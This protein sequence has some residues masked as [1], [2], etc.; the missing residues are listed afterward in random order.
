MA[1]NNEKYNH[2]MGSLGN[3]KPFQ[4][5]II[6]STTAPIIKRSVTNVT[7]GNERSAMAIR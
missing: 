7:G 3:D 2:Q 6:L 5:R 4:Y 1:A